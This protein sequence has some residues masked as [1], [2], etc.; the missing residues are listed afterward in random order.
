MHVLK[1]EYTFGQR[2]LGNLF[3]H[4][5]GS[6]VKKDKNCHTHTDIPI[7]MHIESLLVQ[8]LRVEYFV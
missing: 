4:S 2:S 5:V 3:F 7:A 6:Y 1:G 8:V